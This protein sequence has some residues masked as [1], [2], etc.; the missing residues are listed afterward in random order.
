MPPDIRT[1]PM[2]TAPSAP[3]GGKATAP[4]GGDPLAAIFAALLERG[5]PTVPLPSLALKQPAASDQAAS[6]TASTTQEKKTK[7]QAAP[8][9]LP[10][11]FWELTPLKLP[12]LYPLDPHGPLMPGGVMGNRKTMDTVAMPSSP[13][14]EKKAPAGELP[15]RLAR[16]DAPVAFPLFVVVPPL[17]TVAPPPG[18]ALPAAV[19]VAVNVI[20]PA[21]Q[22][23]IAST[24]PQE[25]LVSV[26]LNTP[27]PVR[28][29]Q[30]FSLPAA[31]LPLA[32][33]A[34]T[35][36]PGVGTGAATP[37]VSRN[38]PRPNPGGLEVGP[39][40]LPPALSPPSG[41]PD[42]GRGGLTAA[43]T[44]AAP[45]ALEVQAATVRVRWSPSIDTPAL[46]AALAVRL[47]AVPQD[48]VTVGK[49]GPGDA[50]QATPPVGPSARPAASLSSVLV[51]LVATPALDSVPVGST[52]RAGEGNTPAAPGAAQPVQKGLK[53]AAR[54]AD[55]NT[56]ITGVQA[57]AAL[58]STPATIK[59]TTLADLGLTVAGKRSEAVKT[60][61]AAGPM[62]PP[63]MPTQTEAAKTP[64]LTRA[65]RAEMVRQV[66][67]GAGGMRVPTR[68]GQPAQMTLQLH[69]HDW[70]RLQVSVQITPSAH[71]AEAQTVTAH[72]VAETPQIKAA[73]EG[74]TQELRHALRE[75]GL[76][77][78]R[79]SVTV[80]SAAAGTQ[81]GMSGGRQPGADSGGQAPGQAAGQAP[82]QGAA[83][84]AGAGPHGGRQDGSPH[85][86]PAYG[87]ASAPPNGNG[88]QDEIETR[89]RLKV[90][91]VDTRA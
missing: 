38:P 80:Q 4:P 13:R 27:L 77:L 81:A 56:R 63:L 86:P 75:A 78:D 21:A 47:G 71:P 46:A 10:S 54:N 12:Q 50:K 28:P 60:N 40:T 41:P 37:T 59:E 9:A 90:G 65:E 62:T 25:A 17:L 79:V 84:S 16:A 72:L 51:P 88:T 5:G 7:D 18:V 44:A 69:P 73:L 61:D 3:S 8:T 31:S 87:A 2:T 91:Q 82:G 66:A 64:S 14:G 52:A 83:M 36:P 34:V 29:G 53:P 35:V 58:P 11:P 70:G 30:A 49:T 22:G 74:H 26:G 33:S 76:H 48:S 15:L 43:S 45:A 19:P 55:N 24:A 67:D 1:G 89:P 85:T 68:P 39:L 57:Q 23:T 20:S 42:L 32:G 6:T